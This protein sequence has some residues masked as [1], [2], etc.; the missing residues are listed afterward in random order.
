[1]VLQ[2]LRDLGISESRLQNGLVEV[3][4]KTDLLPSQPPQEASYAQLPKAHQASADWA[5]KGADVTPN[6]A[7]NCI[8]CLHHVQ[9]HL[10]AV[11][12]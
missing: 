1:M 10:I 5:T 2:V 7:S 9:E 12:P 11:I 8:R 4:N 6:P 3:W